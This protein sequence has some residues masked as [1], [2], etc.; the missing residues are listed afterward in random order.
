VSARRRG[1]ALLPVVLALALLASIAFAL[2]R[3]SV[4][5]VGRAHASEQRD[6]AARVAEAGLRHSLWLANQG[7]CSGYGISDTPFGAHSYRA[8]FSPTAGSPV[9]VAATGTL[10]S[11]V[12]HTLVREIQ[13]VLNGAQTEI[14]ALPDDGKDTT[15]DAWSWDYNFGGSPLLVTYGPPYE[16]RPLLQFDVSTIPSGA[17]IVA[18]QL[19]LHYEGAIWVPAGA[20][21]A[22]H[23]LTAPWVEGTQ[24]GFITPPDGV[25]WRKW[26]GVDWWATEGGDAEPGAHAISEI[27]V[28]PGVRMGW[29]LS[30]LVQQWVD[31]S[32]PNH[33][34]FLRT[35]D[36]VASLAFA[37]GES[38]TPANR[39]RLV[40]V[41]GCECGGGAQASTLELQPGATGLDTHLDDGN[42]GTSWAGA[43]EVRISN[44]TNSQ[45]RG[46]IAFDLTGIDP[47]A[48]VASAEL[49]LDLQGIGSGSA[50][51][52]F[53][54][55]ATTPWEEAQAT[56]VDART[57][58]PWTTSGGDFDA[59][60]TAEADIDPLFPGPT[61]WDVT[62]LAADWVADPT[63]NHGVFLLGS[64]GVNHADFSA[65]DHPDPTLHP[66][67]TVHY[68]CA[69]GPCALPDVYLD[70]F[71]S[72]SCDAAVDYAGSDGTLDWSP[73]PWERVGETGSN[74]CSG[75]VTV[76][77][78][79]AAFEI[80]VGGSSHGLRRPVDL[81]MF[82]RPGLD[83]RY[84][85]ENLS[86]SSQSLVVEA[87]RDGAIWE[88]LGRF[89][90]PDN[91]ASYQDASFDLD[92]FAVA[93]AWIRIMGDGL[94]F[95]TGQ[96]R[97]V[98]FDDV[99]IYEQPPSTP[100]PEIL[101][102][103]SD[104]DSE[105][106][107]RDPDTVFG[108]EPE[109]IAGTDVSY[110][111]YRPLVRFDVS[112]VP[113]G[114]TVVSAVLRT[115]AH[116]F[117]GNKDSPVSVFQV[118]DPWDEATSTWNSTGG[119][120]FDPA[121]PLDTLAVDWGATGWKEWSVPTGLIHEWIDG[122]TPNHGLL[123]EYEGTKKQQRMKLYSRESGIVTL[124]PQLVLVYTLP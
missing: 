7:A 16:A 31:G 33:G 42:P 22:A 57:G 41:Y 86:S 35:D 97:I 53:A 124:F 82:T 123:L 24:S 109:I 122:V 69:C 18:A 90:G 6:H 39:P 92:G 94:G 101:T 107:E 44:K 55:R 3:T 79:N 81:S 9:T 17:R 93:T 66:K 34:V 104:A 78:D 95:S 106:R 119:E 65:S 59:V 1:F 27:P 68:A 21:I 38:S 61:T 32:R 62:A 110:Q 99:R 13:P 121:S 45:K 75:L 47:S 51:T 15:L 72:G 67:L 58:L 63:T 25:T 56:W 10:A 37:S 88:E 23:A 64:S 112:A 4:G 46:L 74:S 2:S 19:S 48:T 50:A 105:L 30:G 70:E 40:V 43:S 85:R 60:A 80:R 76:R 84:L 114:A 73:T 117:F 120:P 52:I 116:D 54:H 12:T 115:Y 11:G 98:Y 111:P 113:A 108:A 102:L 36:G 103:I 20:T 96:D 28:S 49:E 77:E 71:N 87:S 14:R 26:D 118:T 100:G 89:S 91:D 5:S 29:D 8:D 83:L